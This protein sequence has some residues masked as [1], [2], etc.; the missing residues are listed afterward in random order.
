[1][2]KAI[3]A[4]EAQFIAFYTSPKSDGFDNATVSARLAGYSPKSCASMGWQLVKKPKIKAEI[5]RIKTNSLGILD[6]ESF[7]KHAMSDYQ[8]LEVTEPNRPR[9]LELAGKANGLIG[10]SEAGKPSQ[11]VNLTQINISGTENQAQLWDMTRRLL[12]ND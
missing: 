7:T 1:M 2:A 6:K 5:E 4:K 11:T 8:S 10:A 9:F 12:G 3:N